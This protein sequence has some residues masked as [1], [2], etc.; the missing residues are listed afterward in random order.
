MSYN[1]KDTKGSNSKNDSIGSGWVILIVI[2]GIIGCFGLVKDISDGV[3]K[4]K[5]DREYRESYRHSYTRS[6]STSNKSSTSKSTTSSSKKN[7]TSTS[8]STSKS[9]SKTTSKKSSSGSKSTK[10]IDPD[11]LDI[12]GY[13]EDYKDEFDSIDDAWDD[14][15]DNPDMWDD[16]Y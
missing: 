5:A 7:S 9:T 4:A 6:S 1:N 16:Y 10:Q 14:L 15:L 3:K 2:L 12:E 13:Y 11:D 8:T